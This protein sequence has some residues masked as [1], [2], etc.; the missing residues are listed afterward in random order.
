M[1][2]LEPALP[3]NLDK[4]IGHALPPGIYDCH[5]DEYPVMYKGVTLR[6][7]WI[8]LDDV[9]WFPSASFILDNEGYAPRKAQIVL[10][11]E[12]RDNAFTVANPDGEA[13]KFWARISTKAWKSGEDIKLL[14]VN[15]PDISFED[16]YKEKARI[17]A[18]ERAKIERRDD[19]IRELLGGAPP[20]PSPEE[21]G[22]YK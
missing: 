1:Y 6:L 22:R 9:P 17:E 15:D 7:P 20:R 19:L 18:E 5:V 16:T 14:V 3:R 21:R 4:Y 13:M 10:G 8:V 2:T 12:F 11:A